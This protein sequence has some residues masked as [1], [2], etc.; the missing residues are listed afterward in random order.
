MSEHPTLSSHDLAK[1][2][3]GWRDLSMVTE[4]IDGTRSHLEYAQLDIEKD[5]LG[6]PTRL[7]I[8]IAGHSREVNDES[9]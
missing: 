3:L 5:S 9:Q 6:I 8:S 7:V 4:G 2:L 1:I